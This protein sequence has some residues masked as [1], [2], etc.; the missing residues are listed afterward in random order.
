[1]V[2]RLFLKWH[3]IFKKGLMIEKKLLAFEKDH[4]IHLLSLKNDEY[5]LFEM[6]FEFVSIFSP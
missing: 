6:Y 4:F 1:M 5:F 3:N 2:R